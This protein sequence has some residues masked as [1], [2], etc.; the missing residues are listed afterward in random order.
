[1]NNVPTIKTPTRKRPLKKPHTKNLQPNLPEK[2]RRKKWNPRKHSRTTK[3]SIFSVT[4]TSRSRY[5]PS[6]IILSE[7]NLDTKPN[8]K[9]QRRP[10]SERKWKLQ[11]V[12]KKLKFDAKTW[13]ES[14]KEDQRLQLPPRDYLSPEV[15]ISEFGLDLLHAGGAAAL[16]LQEPPP[17]PPGDPRAGWRHLRVGE[18][19]RH[20]RGP[21]GLRRLHRP[22]GIHRPTRVAP[23]IVRLVIDQ[24]KAPRSNNNKNR[25]EPITINQKGRVRLFLR[26]RI[27]L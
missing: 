11:T 7:L 20:R 18:V 5:L 23:Q 13:S 17:Y 26:S 24:T 9:R 14:P 3:D 12:Y 16:A 10:T 25:K 15:G 2:K 27:T 4:M 1:M 22:P 6:E 21:R 8:F 19:E